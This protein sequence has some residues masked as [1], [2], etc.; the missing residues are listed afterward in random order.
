MIR[1]LLSNMCI[2]HKK[3]RPA[4][5]LGSQLKLRF[6][7]LNSTAKKHTYSMLKIKISYHTFLKGCTFQLHYLGIIRSL[8]TIQEE[9]SFIKGFA[10]V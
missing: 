5:S 3:N 10:L 1:I 2:L 4:L 6:L 9:K 8:A 7:D